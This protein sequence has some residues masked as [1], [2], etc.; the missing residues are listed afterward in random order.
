M[1]CVDTELTLLTLSTPPPGRDFF[2]SRANLALGREGGGAVSRERGNSR[3]QTKLVSAAGGQEDLVSSILPHIW[4]S[5]FQ[6]E[7]EPVLFSK[8]VNAVV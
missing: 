7:S 2:L 3:S 8:I 4:Q 1:E 6:G 5:Q